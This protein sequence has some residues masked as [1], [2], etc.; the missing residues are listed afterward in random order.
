[1]SNIYRGTTPTIRLRIKNKDFDMSSINVCHITI[2]NDNGKNQ[3]VFTNPQIDVQ[4]KIISQEL[5]Q[6]DTLAYEYGK[7]NIQAKIKLNNG[8]VVTHP[9]ISTTMNRI[10]EETIL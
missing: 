6:Q 5:S 9:I 2:Q 4:E 3:K 8:S 7:I 10:L 1:M